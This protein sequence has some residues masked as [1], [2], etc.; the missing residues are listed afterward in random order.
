MTRDEV[1]RRRISE[2]SPLYR[3]IMQDAYQGTCSP[4]RAIKAACLHCVGFDRQ[5]ITHCTGYSCPLWAFRPY[6]KEGGNE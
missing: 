1:V 3:V 2:S 6:Q 4:R 5:A